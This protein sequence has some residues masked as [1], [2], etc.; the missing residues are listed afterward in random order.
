[1]K[2]VKLCITDSI[3]TASPKHFDRLKKLGA[4]LCFNYNDPDVAKKIREATGN[5]LKYAADC[6][7][8]TETLKLVNDC[9][10]DEGGVISAILG[11]YTKPV[12]VR[13]SRSGP[14]GVG[15]HSRSGQVGYVGVAGAGYVG[16]GGHIH[17]SSR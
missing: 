15:K 9:M 6:M 3:T 10:G 16:V 7:L 11:V 12:G 1:V 4:H 13:P 8:E 2:T 14:V 17:E 5:S